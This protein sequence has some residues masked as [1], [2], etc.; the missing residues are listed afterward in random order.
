MMF[1][2]FLK[3]LLPVV[4]YGF[5][6]ESPFFNLEYKTCFKKNA[7]LN[8]FQKKTCIPKLVTQIHHTMM[9]QT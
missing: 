6:R 8:K 5:F 3:S 9:Y 1:V 2:L 4:A 7:A